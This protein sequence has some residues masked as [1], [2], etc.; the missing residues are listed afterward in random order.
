MPA[1]PVGVIDSLASGFEIVAA[2]LQILLLPLGVDLFLWL[3]PRMTLRP[4]IFL[5]ENFWLWVV[6]N[7]EGPSKTQY[8]QLAQDT[9]KLAQIAPDRYLPIVLPPT[10]LGGRRASPLLFDFKPVVLETWSGNLIAIS[11]ALISSV[12]LYEIWYGW[13]T[14][15][16]LNEPVSPWQFIKQ[17]TSITLQSFFAI[18]AITV[19]VFVSSILF[20]SGLG[21]ARL[22]GGDSLVGILMWSAVLIFMMFVVPACTMA[23]FT[24]HSMFLNRR[25]LIAALWDSIRVVQWNMLPTTILLILVGGIYIAMN[26]I[27]SLAGRGSWLTLAAMGGNAF[28]STGLIAAT[29]V[30][31]KDRYRHWREL[32]EAVLAE[33]DRRRAQQDNNRQV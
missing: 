28:I 27:W 8:F 4:I 17:V 26:I 24:V 29:F 30:Y 10:L 1:S 33:L 13:I 23:I 6:S 18:A 21:V 5:V 12:I 31:Y 15:Y 2:H 7:S 16:V 22:I 9:H 14:R 25:N 20:L 32:R 11:V 3:G 19:I